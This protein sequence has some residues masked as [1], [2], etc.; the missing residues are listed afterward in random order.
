MYPCR[1]SSIIQSSSVCM[2]NFKLK[3]DEHFWQ[4]KSKILEVIHTRRNISVLE[5]SGI[6]GCHN[7]LIAIFERFGFF[8]T[9]LK[10]SESKVDDFTLK[11]ILRLS[12]RLTSLHLTEINVIKKLP[13]ITPVRNNCLT[14]LTVVYC[15]WEIFKFFMKSNLTSLV[16]KSYLDEV[17]RKHLVTLLSSQFRL[18]ELI[19]LGTSLRSLF[20]QNDIVCNFSLETFR[21]DNAIGRNSENVNFNV[22]SFLSHSHYTLKCIEI[23]GPNNEFLSSYVL[24]NFSACLE[25]LMM[26]VRGLPKYEAFYEILENQPLNTTLKDL[27]L[28]GFFLQQIYIKR[29]LLRYPAIK[30]LELND[31]SNESLGDILDFISKNMTQLENLTITEIS[32]SSKFNSLKKLSVS[33]IRNSEKLIQFIVENNGIEMLK[34]GLI[35]VSQIKNFIEDLKNLNN[36]KHLSIGGN[37]TALRAMLNN[38]MLSKNLPGELKTL[39]LSVFGDGAGKQEDKKIRLAIPFDPLDLKLKYN[40]LV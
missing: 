8:V 23:S 13:M 18:K 31:W 39:E 2:S 15:D 36:V 11:E 17:N 10:M 19:L 32:S 22:S 28:S 38:L 40:I 25:T 30:N 29:L 20:N 37:K 9:K 5:L 26:D 4:N 3:L 6:N 35:Y 16:V 34:V 14:S 7:V 24:S 21:F 27:R 12:P 1:F 33:Y